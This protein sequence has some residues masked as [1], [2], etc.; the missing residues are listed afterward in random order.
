MCKFPTINSSATCLPFHLH[1]FI[2][3]RAAEKNIAEKSFTLSE[4]R[5]FKEFITTDTSGWRKHTNFSI[6]NCSFANYSETFFNTAKTSVAFSIGISNCSFN[7]VSVLLFNFSNE[8][9]TKGYYNVEKLSII[10]S[11]FFK[12]QLTATSHATWWKRW[13]HH[14]AAPV[15]FKQQHQQLPYKKQ[16]TVD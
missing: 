11:N 13:K 4:C 5:P 2:N 9:D 1:F 14:G 8:D 15:F 7:N 3:K 16:W 12:L 6:S 10:I